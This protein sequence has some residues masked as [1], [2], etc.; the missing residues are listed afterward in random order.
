ML[1]E[2]NKNFENDLFS[3]LLRLPHWIPLDQKKII[4]IYHERCYNYANKRITNN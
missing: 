4:I 2:E 1:K 3:K